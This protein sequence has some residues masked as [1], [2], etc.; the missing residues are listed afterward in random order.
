M[1]NLDNVSDQ[2]VLSGGDEAAPAEG[3]IHTAR[4]RH[5]LGQFLGDVDVGRGAAASEAETD[6]RLQVMLLR[7]ETARLT[8]ARHRPANVGSLTDQLRLVSEPSPYG[9]E[10]RITGRRVDWRHTG[11]G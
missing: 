11:E 10:D 2:L 5:R 3:H 7:E 4:L 9:G 6:L 1:E 8:A